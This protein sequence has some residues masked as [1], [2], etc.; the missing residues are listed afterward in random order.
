MHIII[1]S[2][3]LI[4]IVVGIIIALYY[5][6]NKKWND[7]EDSNSNEIDKQNSLNDRKNEKKIKNSKKVVFL[8]IFYLAIVF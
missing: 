6:V 8:K 2:I 5:V 1:L 3:P 4:G 7:V